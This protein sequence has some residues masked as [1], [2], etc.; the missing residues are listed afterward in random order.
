MCVYFWPFH[1]GPWICLFMF[2]LLG[3]IIVALKYIFKSS[4][5]SPSLS[6]EFSWLI[7]V[8]FRYSQISLSHSVKKVWP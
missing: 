2:T 3:L 7:L 5:A 8:V 1:S 4:G 6:L